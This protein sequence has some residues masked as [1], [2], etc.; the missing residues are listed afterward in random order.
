MLGS[1]PLHKEALS[2]L[3]EG[4]EPLSE[5]KEEIGVFLP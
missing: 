1:G 5:E 2:L 4:P 3:D